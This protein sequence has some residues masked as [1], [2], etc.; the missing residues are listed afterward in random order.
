MK[1]IFICL[2][3]G[4]TFLQ[5]S[6]QEL[7]QRVPEQ[8]PV[9][10]KEEAPSIRER[11][12]YGGNFWIGVAYNNTN[13]NLSPVIG[14]WVYPR[15]AVAIGPEY[16]FIKDI[17]GPTSIYGGRTYA[18]FVVIKDLSKF[19]P[20]GMNTGI[21]LHL[22]DEMLNIEYSHW[23]YPTNK[24]Y[25]MNTVLGGIGISQQV[26][27]RSYANFMILWSLM[28]SDPEMGTQFYSNPE[29]RIGFTF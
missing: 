3:F 28:E 27:R 19:V 7:L 21:F 11:L 6:G 25:F 12:F 22:E 10:T 8:Q 9:Q 29:L 26:G 1:K 17:Y 13:I 2:V 14:L 4:L 18:Q 20:F 23:N 24:R 15:L 16:D 5:I